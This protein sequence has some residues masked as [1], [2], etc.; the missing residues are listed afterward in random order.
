MRNLIFV[1]AAAL[2]FACA[3][4]AVAQTVV[5]TTEQQATYDG[6]TMENRATYDAWP[7]D[8]KTYYWTL[9]PDQTAGWW[10]LNNEQRVKI[11]A[12]TPEQRAEAWTSINA[13][14][15]ARTMSPAATSAAADAAAA[16]DSMAT[17]DTTA[18]TDTITTT[19]MPATSG[20]M[21][22][23]KREMAQPVAASAS[24]EAAASGD[25]PICK[26]DQQ[27]GCINAYEKTGK[28]NKPLNYWPG[29]PASEIPGKKPQG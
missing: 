6:W 3:V 16:A 8:A 2:S 26:K 15:A 5:L 29:K 24:A 21:Q 11:V 18:A 10:A 13:Q 1:G 14:M 28:G 27:D 20:A 19:T 4:P 22:F 12:M 7:M 9:T 17:P 23:V 25:L